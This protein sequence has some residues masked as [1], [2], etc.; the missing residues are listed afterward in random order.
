MQ[1]TPTENGYVHAED[2]KLIVE[3]TRAVQKVA[4]KDEVPRGQLVV[5]KTDAEDKIPLANVEF[6]L[7]NKEIGEAVGKLTTDKEGVATSE[8]LPIATYE[9][10]KAIVPITYVLSETKPFEG[11]EDNTET[12]EITFSY[13]NSKTKVIEVIKEI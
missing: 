1:V 8:L 9:E 4:M 13:Q 11:C 12:Y 10:G 2:V 3:K 7:K 5:K 6:E